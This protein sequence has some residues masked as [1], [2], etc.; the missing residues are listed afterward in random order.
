[1][2]RL[3]FLLQGYD[4]SL[5]RF[6]VD[7][8]RYGFRIH[9]VGER[10]AYDSPNLKSALDKPDITSEKLRKGC[11]AGRIV[12]PF[13]APPFRNF[14]TSPLGLVPKKDPTEFRL[15]H[16]LS[17]PIGYSV[18]DFIPDSCS[19][20]KYASVGDA[21]KSLKR[22]GRGC[23]MAKTD[24]KSAFRI[25]PIHPADYSLV[26][27]KW[28]KSYYFDRC[29][30][31]GLRSSCNTFE[32]FSTCLEWLAVHLLGASSVLHILDDFLFIAPTKNKCERDLANFI[33][34]CTY[35][36][37]PLAPEKT[38][39]PDTVL[40]FAGIT[41]D[42]VRMEARLPEEKLQ[43]CRNLLTDFLA[44]R[45]VRLRELQ[46]L[47]GLLNFTCLVVVP[48]RAFLRRLIDLTKGIRQ[49]YHHI[50]LSQEAQ[51]DL[52]LWFKFLSQY[53][54][55]SFFL[56]DVWETS[57]TLQLYTD[58]SGSMGFGAVFG[59]HWFSGTWPY[60]WHSFNIAVLE[61]FP[62]VVAVH[63]WGSCMADKCVI[64]F[65]DNA[66]V[67]EIIN[68]QSSKHKGIMVLLR[69]LVLSCLQHNILFQ[70]RHI[71][72]FKNSRADYLSRSQV[73]KFKEISPE[74]DP[75]PT[76]VPES[77]MPKSWFLI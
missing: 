59:N 45:S 75:Y 25:I 56:D 38:T 63:V 24:V 9:F 35:L 69:N 67:V 55:R 73:A 16:H 39:G 53:N 44:R 32:A 42:S 30:G 47:I 20:V 6:L 5:K 51:L 7:G 58:S 33:L 22:L 60:S 36:G 74:A 68:K 10:R 71:P 62:I 8:F 34:M 18:N 70:A 1:M 48:G 49:P 23:F 64:F 77:L 66:A 4:P 41:L 76:Q 2:D 43:K 3:E 29:L 46:S 19:T 65:S 13:P 14:R 72:G 27:M 61:L 37:V 50:R 28:N 12:G 40:Q 21:S 52:A 26:G 17:F 11:E 15:I 57:H 54:G 31:M